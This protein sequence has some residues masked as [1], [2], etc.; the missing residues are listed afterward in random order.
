MVRVVG[1]AAPGEFV[2]VRLA[3]DDGAGALQ[4]RRHG[5][6]LCRN[7][8]RQDFRPR[9][10]ADAARVD[11]VLERDRN[12][13]ERA[14]AVS[15]LNHALGGPRHLTRLRITDGDVRSDLLVDAGDPLKHRLRELHRGEPAPLEL[16][17]GLDDRQVQQVSLCHDVPPIA[18]G[19]AGSARSTGT[20]RP[21][22]CGSARWRPR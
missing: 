1:R 21:P 20:P 12:P 13:V 19:I 9:R 11:V 18:R 17:R 22:S 15:R 7:K 6:V 8:V 3:D 2:H 14:E 10:R 4:P 5:R 16:C